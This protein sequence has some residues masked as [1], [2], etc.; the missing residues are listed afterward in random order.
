MVCA[1]FSGSSCRRKTQAPRP[2]QR[3]NNTR[4]VT[5][6]CYHAHG[7]RTLLPAEPYR[8]R[9]LRDLLILAHGTPASF[10][11][12]LLAFRL[13]PA[14]THPWLLLCEIMSRSTSRAGMG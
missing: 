7:R 13:C 2:L 14:L 1:K 6:E 9:P 4:H 8:N 3:F 11:P 12:R 10:V 5:F